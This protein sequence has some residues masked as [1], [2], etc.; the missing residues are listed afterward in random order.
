MTKRAKPSG[1]YRVVART[2]V[3]ASDDPDAQAFESW[4][5][6]EPGDVV[7]TWPAHAPV[8]EWVKS[9]HWEA[10]DE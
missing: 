7:S 8:E 1:Q 3:R 4:I 9:G 2:S 5:D 10:V 6:F